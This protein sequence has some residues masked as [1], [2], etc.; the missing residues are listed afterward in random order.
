MNHD[1]L[2]EEIYHHAYVETLFDKAH[3]VLCPTCSKILE[4]AAIERYKRMMAKRRT[5]IAAM[6]AKVERERS[7]ES[8]RKALDR[9]NKKN[10]LK[11]DDHE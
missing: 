1:P 11:G 6:Q 5:E 10:R 7:V 3:E 9:E 2:V 4:G 8:R